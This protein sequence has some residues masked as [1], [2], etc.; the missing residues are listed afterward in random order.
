MTPLV[1][2]LV[3]AVVFLLERYA[4]TYRVPHGEEMHRA[5]PYDSR[6][7]ECKACELRR[8]LE[9]EAEWVGVR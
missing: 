4:Q 1:S 2:A 7:C 9:Q 8:A 6:D 5:D 3:R